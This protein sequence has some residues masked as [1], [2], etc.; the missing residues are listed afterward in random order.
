[1]YPKMKLMI[2]LL[3]LD[4]LILS[5]M[6]LSA[7]ALLVLTILAGMKGD[8]VTVILAIM[9][10]ALFISCPV[11]IHFF[12]VIYSYYKELENA[13]PPGEGHGL[14]GLRA[15]PAPPGGD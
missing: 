4:F 6:L 1:M 3:C 7:V 5:L 13:S 11:A 14:V 10:V 12:I 9:T 15:P 2:L 8:P